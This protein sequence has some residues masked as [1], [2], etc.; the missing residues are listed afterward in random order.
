MVIEK[1]ASPSAPPP[2]NDQN[3]NMEVAITKVVDQVI[4]VDQ[5]MKEQDDDVQE[6]IA[7]LIQEH[8]FKSAF[9]LKSLKLMKLIPGQGWLQ[10][11]E[12]KDYM[13]R[14]AYNPECDRVYLIGG[15]KD[16]KSKHTVNNV[17]LIHFAQNRI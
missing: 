17:S 9:K 8:T 14:I 7:P 11:T 1:P 13:T 4:D 15:A 10:V 6:T 5:Q 2:V 16:Q 3:Q 12:T